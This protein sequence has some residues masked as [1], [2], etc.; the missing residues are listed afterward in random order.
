[1]YDNGFE[2]EN[3]TVDSLI[4]ETTVGPG[5]TFKGNIATVKPIRIDGYYEGE[6]ESQGLVVIS[7]TGR[8]KGKLSCV[9]LR[10][11]GTGVGEASCTQLMDVASTGSFTG[12]VRTKNMILREGSLFDG[13]CDMSSTR[14]QIGDPSYAGGGFPL[15]KR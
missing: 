8:F 4:I 6:I 10:L 13:N 5:T 15:P 1:M 7:E 9:E 12:K 2:D 14:T 3:T 11:S